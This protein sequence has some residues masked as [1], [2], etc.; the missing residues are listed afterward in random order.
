M[1]LKYIFFNII[2]MYN[3]ECNKKILIFLNAIKRYNFELN[4]KLILK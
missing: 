2:E 3:L 4:I 1:P